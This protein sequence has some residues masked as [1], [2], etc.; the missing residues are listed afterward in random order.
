MTVVRTSILLLGALAWS[1]VSESSAWEIALSDTLVTRESVVRL[2]D[3][4]EIRGLDD[5]ELK[6]NLEAMLISSGPTLSLAREFSSSDLRR[7]L[8]LHSVDL[9]QGQITGASRVTITCGE[10]APQAPNRP[11]LRRG[12]PTA[13]LQREMEQVGRVRVKPVEYS[14]PNSTKNDRSAGQP[15]IVAV[16][17]LS[18]GRLVREDDVAVVYVREQDLL[19]GAFSCIE[20]VVG[21]EATG[22]VRKDDTLTD[23][24]LK[25]PILVRNRDLVE[26][27]VCCGGIVIT[28]QA[29]AQGEGGRGDTV[30]VCPVD[31]KKQRL[32]AMVVDVRKVRVLA[33]SMGLTK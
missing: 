6:A 23:R 11:I 33:E 27:G 26:V 10:A 21:L 14:R 29:I 22:P 24:M 3:I 15:M 17:D 18:K 5:D 16:R 9:S 4:A 8:E 32:N 30:V 20:D 25:K 28:K 7:I 19:A 13:K 12:E 1:T 31:D 2:S